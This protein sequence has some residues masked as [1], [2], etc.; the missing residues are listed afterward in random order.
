M[1]T[2]RPAKF[3]YPPRSATATKVGN[4]LQGESSRTKRTKKVKNPPL[5]PRS[6]W[7]QHLEH[8]FDRAAEGDQVEVLLCPNRSGDIEDV[9]MAVPPLTDLEDPEDEKE[10]IEAVKRQEGFVN[11]YTFVPAPPRGDLATRNREPGGTTTASDGTEN[12][13][14]S[15][16][17]VGETDASPGARG[18]PESVIGPATGLADS[19]EA[20]P[21]SHARHG[22]DQWSGRLTLRLTAR[23]PLLLPDQ[24][25]AQKDSE[26]PDR[27]VVATGTDPCTGRPLLPCTSVKGTLRSAFETITASRFGVFGGHDLPLA[28]RAPASSGSELVPAVVVSWKGSDYFRLCRGNAAWHPDEDKAKVQFAAWVPTYTDK[29]VVPRVVLAGGLRGN[30]PENLKDLHGTSVHARVRL[31][32]MSTSN[33]AR[34]GMCRVWVVTHLSDDPH[35]LPRSS[36]DHRDPVELDTSLK[37]VAR[38][39]PR[40]VQGVLSATGQSIERKKY[41]R[42]FVMTAQDVLVPVAEA[43]RNYWRSVLDAYTEASRYHDPAKN[44]ERSWHVG[45]AGAVR[46][47]PAAPTKGSSGTLPVYVG[48]P[49]GR[50]PGED[51]APESAGARGDDLPTIM[52]P[53]EVTQVHPVTIGRLPFEASP[54]ALLDPSLRPAADPSELSPADRLFG[55]SGDGPVPSRYGRRESSG[56]RGR[57]SVRSVT[58]QDRDWCRDLPGGGVVLAP[59]SG[60]KPTQFRFYAAQD[61]TGRTV[62]KGVQK[63]T[64]YALG[65]GLR[66]R[67]HYR[68]SDLPAVYWEPT[69]PQQDYRQVEGRYREYL[70]PGA[71]PK[72]T[73]RYKDWV[74]PGVTFDVEI[75]LDGVPSAELGALLWLINRSEEAPLRVGSGKPYG[76][77]VVTATIVWNDEDPSDGPEPTALWDGEAVAE[78]WRSLARPAPATSD[79]LLA[80][81]EQFEQLARRHPLLA[82]TLDCYLAAARSVEH[83]IHYPRSQRQPMAESY[84]WF[85]ENERTEKTEQSSSRGRGSTADGPT[86]SVPVEGWSL[87]DVRSQEPRLPILFKKQRGDSSANPDRPSNGSEGRTPG[88]GRS[89]KGRSRPSR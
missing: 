83:P 60:P 23:T 20:G 36:S 35:H 85:T 49:D 3:L 65:T 70:D 58:C 56:Y 1:S 17:A 79:R 71:A 21:P 15:E 77:G 9:R 53:G 63:K 40:I 41:E 44:L 76:F 38:T 88:Q 52:D 46:D 7:D 89:M 6:K 55:W 87:P 16:T 12:P 33:Q 51:E 32:R 13:G 61:P 57:L 78:G 10:R 59:L 31:Y 50:R 47:L 66:G 11:S 67:K 5:Y 86:E 29:D 8:W 73:V 48:G 62:A 26:T 84:E 64:G 14:G 22:P 42:L 18:F 81:A 72:Q 34:G 19:G 28:Y 68:W 4:V 30:S 69:T 74:R 75:F 24:Q 2:D 39:G 25:Q 80:L 82:Q 43:H 45:H 37:L 27:N 54:A